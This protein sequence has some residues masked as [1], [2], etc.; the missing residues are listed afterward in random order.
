[1]SGPDRFGCL[2]SPGTCNPFVN[3]SSFSKEE[4]EEKYCC[5]FDCLVQ[6][7]H[8]LGL[9][10]FALPSALPS[11]GLRFASNIY[12][13]GAKLSTPQDPQTMCNHR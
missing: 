13:S 2:C 1:M 5:I 8:I 7:L 11:V 10:S 3:E 6:Y 9:V 4:P 12:P